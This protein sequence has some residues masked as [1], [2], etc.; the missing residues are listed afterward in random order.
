MSEWYVFAFD[1]NTFSI[2]SFGLLI[3]SA[4]F[5]F[6]NFLPSNLDKSMFVSDAIIIPFAFLISSFVN[7][8][9]TPE[10]PCVSTFTLCPNCSPI[11]SKASAA[12]YVCAIPVGQLVIAKISYCS[13][14]AFSS[15]NFSLSALSIHFKNSFGVFASY[16]ACLNS[17]SINNVDSLLKTSKCTLSFVFGAAIRNSNLAGLPSNDLKSTP[18]GMI[19]AAKPGFST[20]SVFP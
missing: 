8:F 4:T 13:F 17:V 20:A 2:N 19:M 9:F 11:C 3:P 6:I 18:S 16:N 7:L 1:D 5:A 14:D 15:P 10:D 12:I